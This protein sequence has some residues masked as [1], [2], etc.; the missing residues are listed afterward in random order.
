MI[1]YVTEWGSYSEIWLA[2]IVSS[3]TPEVERDPEGGGPGSSWVQNT[4]V[5]SWIEGPLLNHFKVEKQGL[6]IASRVES[7]EKFDLKSILFMLMENKH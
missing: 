7:F 3:A 1:Q 6:F 2:T 5:L 4:E